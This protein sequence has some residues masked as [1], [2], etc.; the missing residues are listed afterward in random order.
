METGTAFLASK[1]LLSAVKLGLFTT[2]AGN[3]SLSAKEIQ[4]Q[5]SLHDRG[6]TI[7]S[8]AS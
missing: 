8:M 6:Y 4:K 7:S 3:K 1:T 2:L 5:L